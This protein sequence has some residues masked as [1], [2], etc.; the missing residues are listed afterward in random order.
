MIYIFNFVLFFI[1]LKR[2]LS[3][4]ITEYSCLEFKCHCEPIAESLNIECSNQL[5]EFKSPLKDLIKY[6]TI[7]QFTIK[8]A[9]FQTG[10]I[11]HSLFNGLII[12]EIVFENTHITHIDNESF[13]GLIDVK[14]LTFRDLNLTK[15]SM[16]SFSS[17]NINDIDFIN[18]KI[19][20]T[21]MD[22]NYKSI[23]QLNKI[24]HMTL[25]HNKLTHL[26]HNWFKNFKVVSLLNLS[27]NKIRRIDPNTFKFMP[28]LARL[29]LKSNNLS[30][31]FDQIPL[32]Y[33]K[34]SLTR[35]VLAQNKLTCIPVFDRFI[36]LKILDLSTNLIETLDFNVF[37]NLISL[38]VLNMNHNK[39]KHICL[40]CFTKSLLYLRLENNYLNRVPNLRHL[41]SL[42]LLNMKNQNGNLKQLSDY[43]FDRINSSLNLKVEMDQNDLNKFSF[44]SFCTKYGSY[45][46]NL[47]ISYATFLNIIN[48]TNICLL[49]ELTYGSSDYIH[50][51]VDKHVDFGSVEKI[52]NCDLMN[53]LK[54]KNVILSGIDCGDLMC[55]SNY[56]SYAQVCLN[57]KYFNCENKASINKTNRLI[58]ILVFVFLFKFF[59]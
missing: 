33:L 3:Q 22:N 39:L 27:F 9:Y 40:D 53:F 46:D 4:E 5:I 55:V 51:S 12:S 34:M 31:C 38:N 37:Q 13:T 6:D 41:S 48:I 8:N 49:S 24:D 30:A 11:P 21:F 18:C 52:C 2:R 16:E 14:K 17:L 36:K 1:S 43:Q 56:T 26:N 15:I 29:N 57:E 19:D 47:T 45:I 58:F 20:D 44:Q 10:K 23:Q 42:I 28:E 25:S 54:S 50:L 32:L 7:N 35:L 59:V